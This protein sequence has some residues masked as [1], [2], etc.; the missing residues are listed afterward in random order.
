MVLLYG[1][2]FP[3]GPV[4]EPWGADPRGCFAT[5][6]RVVSRPRNFGYRHVCALA[7]RYYITHISWTRLLGK[8]Q[9]LKIFERIRMERNSNDEE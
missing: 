5:T 8:A 1:M 6:T 3:L 4:L 2:S 7:K 9:Y